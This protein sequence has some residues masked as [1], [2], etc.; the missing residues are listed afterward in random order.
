MVDGLIDELREKH[1][2]SFSSLQYRV[3]AE[4][5]AGGNHSSLEKPPKGSYYKKKDVSSPVRSVD[6]PPTVLTPVRAA[7]LRTTYI[8]QIKDL[9]SLLDIGAIAESDFQKQKQSLL[10][11]MDKLL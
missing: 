11:L 5:I 9:H 3:W 8:K 6:K 10:E 4:T 2:Q 1:G 7:E